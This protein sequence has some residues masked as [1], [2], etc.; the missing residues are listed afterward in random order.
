MMKLK[1][2]TSSTIQE[3]EKPANEVDESTQPYMIFS[4]VGKQGEK[5]Q[6]KDEL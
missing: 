4:Y 2:T 1:I 5:I 3:D 6:S